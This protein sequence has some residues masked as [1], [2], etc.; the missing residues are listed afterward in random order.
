MTGC[1]ALSTYQ[2]VKHV[3]ATTAT[4]SCLDTNITVALGKPGTLYWSDDTTSDTELV[5]NVPLAIAA[6]GVTTVTHNIID[7]HF[8]GH[9]L[10]AVEAVLPPTNSLLC[11]L[12]AAPIYYVTG[13][14]TYTII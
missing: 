8:A 9:Q 11:I 3:Y 7:G 13:A 12:G 6:A 2:P 14:A 1:V 10:I 4:T 5:D